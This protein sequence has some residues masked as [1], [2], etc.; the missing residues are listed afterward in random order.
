VNLTGA[1]HLAPVAAHPQAICVASISRIRREKNAGHKA[2]VR[3]FVRDQSRLVDNGSDGNHINHWLGATRTQGGTPA[4][5]PAWHDA[6]TRLYVFPPTYNE[7]MAGWLHDTARLFRNATSLAASTPCATLAA[8][9]SQETR[10][11]LHEPHS[12]GRGCDRRCMAAVLYF[13]RGM[14]PREQ[15]SSSAAVCLV[16]RNAGSSRVTTTGMGRSLRSA[17]TA[18]GRGRSFVPAASRRPHI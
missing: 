2:A 12:F 15:E 10:A 14:R 18:C 9:G 8:R 6:A 16:A 13:P 7:G 17:G 5:L 1:Q 11:G 4:S 3:A